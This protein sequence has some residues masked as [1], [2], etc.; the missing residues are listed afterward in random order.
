MQ[1]ARA[2]NALRFEASNGLLESG[3]ARQMRPIG[4][5]TRDNCRMSVQ[6]DRGLE[7]LHYRCKRFHL[8]D[9]SALVL[10]RQTH[11]DRREVGRAECGQEGELQRAGIHAGGRNQIETRLRTLLGLRALPVD[12]IEHPAMLFVEHAHGLARRRGRCVLLDRSD[13]RRRVKHRQRDENAG[14]QSGCSERPF[15]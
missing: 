13:R 10:I 12:L 7:I 2:N 11:Q 4:T 15:Q 14:H 3:N 9:Q 6:N 1:S 8:I 5:G